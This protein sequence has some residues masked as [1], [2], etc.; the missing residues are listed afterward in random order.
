MTVSSNQTSA[1]LVAPFTLDVDQAAARITASG[2][3]SAM[4]SATKAYLDRAADPRVLIFVDQT[5][6]Q[7]DFDFSGTLADVLQRVQP[8]VPERPG[9]GRP[10]LGVV[11]RE[12]SLLIR[13]VVLGTVH[14]Q[15]NASPKMRRSTIRLGAQRRTRPDH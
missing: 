11:S 8:A 9:P 10:K 12:V 4:L 15:M 3:L 13:H 7:L 1:H 14:E 6:Q 2:E 5:G